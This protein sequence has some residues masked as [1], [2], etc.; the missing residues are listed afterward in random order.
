MAS[1]D[2]ARLKP[3]DLRQVWQR[4][5]EDFTPWL[6]QPDNITLLGETLGL[7]LDVESTEAGVGPYR[8]DI[9]CR[10]TASGSSEGALV[11][12]E[13]QLERTNHNHLGQLLTYAAGL[14]AVTV[15]W[16][17][18]PFTDE[19]RTALDWLNERTDQSVNF[20]GLEIELWRIGDSPIA[21]KFNIVAQPNDWTKTVRDTTGR[22]RELSETRRQQLEFWIEFEEFVKSRGDEIRCQRPGPQTWMNSSLGRT[23]MTFACV[24]S[25]SP[26]SVRVELVLDGDDAKA[27]FSLLEIDRKLIEEEI[28][29]ELVW[30][31]PPNRK[32]ARVQIK[33]DIDFRNHSQ[34]EESKQWLYER[35]R[36]F[37]EVLKPRALALNAA[38]ATADMNSEGESAS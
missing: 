22:G 32:G 20:F 38:D 35:L 13:N 31:S 24:I 21:P 5:A 27:W 26:P 11:L 36:I 6:A 33:N 37:H 1:T 34:R 3:V 9:V 29:E 18:A 23:W 8:A 15:V 30:H 14:D 25:T 19:H 4:E 17:A 10:D 28:G 16:I 12:I 7:E 2:L